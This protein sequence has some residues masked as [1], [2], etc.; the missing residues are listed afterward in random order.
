M[1]K[2]DFLKEG[3]VLLVG[4][5][6]VRPKAEV[7]TI[8]KKKRS[9]WLS[10]HITSAESQYPRYRMMTGGRAGC[11]GIMTGCSATFPVFPW[12]HGY[13]AEGSNI[14]PLEQM[15][16]SC[17]SVA[18]LKSPAFSC[19]CLFWRTFNI[20][21]A[22][23]VLLAPLCVCRVRES[24]RKRIFFFP[25]PILHP[26]PPEVCTFLFHSP[27]CTG[28]QGSLASLTEK[29]APVVPILCSWIL[30]TPELNLESKGYHTEDIQWSYEVFTFLMADRESL[31]EFYVLRSCCIFL[32]C[33]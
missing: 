4:I 33:V 18:P 29:W 24:K 20:I 31:N 32:W 12:P 21:S 25:L 1:L 5:Y 7:K 17:G 27:S 23:M 11:S 16:C 14:L 9:P 3:F 13:L 28:L 10:T 26:A 6:R 2:Y 22:V 15:S 19:L 8:E 30:V